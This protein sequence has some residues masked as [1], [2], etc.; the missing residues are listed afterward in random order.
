MAKK[1]QTKKP[2]THLIDLVVTAPAGM[3]KAKVK[4]EV[5]TRINDVTAHFSAYDLGLDWRT[6]NSHGN[7]KVRAKLNRSLF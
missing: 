2:R 6:E 1:K 3:S 5:L 7:L 4:R